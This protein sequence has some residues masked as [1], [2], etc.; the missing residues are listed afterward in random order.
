MNKYL[1][2][3]NAGSS[4][5][6]FTVYQ[7]DVS[8]GQLVTDAAGQ[9]DGI[10][11]Q[12]GFTVR[13]AEG[14][15]LIE[16][17]LSDD[18]THNHTEAINIILSWLWEYFG[19]GTLLAVGHRVVHG[20]QTYSAPVL[21]DATVLAKLETLIPL[22]PLHQPHNLAT[23]RIL[24]ESMPSLRKWP[25][26][27]LHFTA[28]SQ[29]SRNASPYPGA[30]PMKVYAITDFTVY[31]TNT[32]LPYYPHLSPHLRMHVSSSPTWVAAPVCVHFIRA[33]VLPRRWV[34]LRSMAWSWALVVVISTPVY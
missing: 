23:I 14:V 9:I 13:S 24:L 12:P 31:P 16:R 33:A 21:I 11:S 34:S 8:P 25:A 4:S 2:V 10:G 3:I 26:L 6:K 20:G 17:M 22:A 28:H 5:I 29:T 27:I 7:K 1:L 30:L 15:L 19:N 18:E 32:L